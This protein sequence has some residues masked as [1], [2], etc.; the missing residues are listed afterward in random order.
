[1]PILGRRGRSRSRRAD[2][3]LYARA[4]PEKAEITETYWVTQ[5]IA[6]GNQR[7]LG[8][9]EGR[10]EI[11]VPHDGR[12]FFTRQ[13]FEDVKR[14]IR[15][16]EGPGSLAATIGH[17]LI[18]DYQRTDLGRSMQRHGEYGAIPLE[19]LVPTQSGA[20]EE[21]IAD[22]RASVLRYDYTLH[23]PSFQATLHVQLLDPDILGVERDSLLD[24]YKVPPDELLRVFTQTNRVTGE[25]VLI[26]QVSLQLPVK[27]DQRVMPRVRRVSIGWPTVTSFAATRLCVLYPRPRGGYR[28]RDI[29]HRYNP[30]GQ[31]LEW[32]DVCV[33]KP[34]SRP[35]DADVASVTY[36]SRQLLLVVGH[37]GEIFDGGKLTVHADIEIPGYL[38]SGVEAW[39]YGATGEMTPSVKGNPLPRLKTSIHSTATVQIDDALEMRSFVLYHQTVFDRIVPDEER[40][41]DIVRVLGAQGYIVDERQPASDHL[42][43]AGTLRWELGAHRSCP[44]DTLRLRIIAVGQKRPLEEREVDERHPDGNVIV[45]RSRETGW[46]RLTVRGTLARQHLELTKR[47]NEFQAALRKLYQQQQAG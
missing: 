23:E 17:L 22:R 6:K 11:V 41:D 39:L 42:A 4:T 12:D 27:K 29:P 1:M 25:C 3:K 8:Q 26:I 36:Q 9:A 5:K 30:V 31:C 24:A 44:P 28:Q 18:A 14:A 7:D 20:A 35:D 32:E 13:A 34:G 33:L 38:L 2:E 19:I 15:L 40:I 46:I 37:P 43:E 10:I 47:M 21:L 45:V 16:R